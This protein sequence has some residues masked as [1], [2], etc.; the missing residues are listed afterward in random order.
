M[1]LL[2]LEFGELDIEQVDILLL[3]SNVVVFDIHKEGNG[4][5]VDKVLEEVI[6]GDHLL[7]PLFLLRADKLLHFDLVENPGQCLSLF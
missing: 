7:L 1:F 5:I 6:P 3:Q 2:F 4:L